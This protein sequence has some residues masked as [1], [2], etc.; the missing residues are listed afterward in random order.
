MNLFTKSI[1]ILLLLVSGSV[2]ASELTAPKEQG[3]IGE[4]F[5]GYLAL[6]SKA[7]P[8]IQSLVETVN[9]KRKAH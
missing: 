9:Q 7:S 5:D 3:I 4:R 8:E 1:A 2:F 6:V